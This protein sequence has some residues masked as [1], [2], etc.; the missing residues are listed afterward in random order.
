MGHPCALRDCALGLGDSSVGT[1]RLARVRQAQSKAISS[2]KGEAA[3]GMRRLHETNAELLQQLDVLQRDKDV[4]RR[5][6]EQQEGELR[7][8][9]DQLEMQIRSFDNFKESLLKD[10]QERCEK[11]IDLELSLD[12]SREQYNSLMADT[13]NR[14]LKKRISF[15]ERNVDQLT[16]T[17]QQLVVQNSTYRIENQIAEKKI[18]R[19]NERIQILELLLQDA[20]ERNEK[21]RQQVDK[22][23]NEFKELKRT[24]KLQQSR[25]APNSF[26]TSAVKV[27]TPTDAATG[28]SPTGVSVLNSHVVMPIRGGGQRAAGVIRGGGGSVATAEADGLDSPAPLAPAIQPVT[29]RD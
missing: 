3:E 27:G 15:L 6:N 7:A 4:A 22:M 9:R 13:S 14:K 18:L 8:L 10:L 11:V 21:L 20:R 23:N 5:N 16:Q 2:E 29:A 26:S 12:E 28:S 17:Y 1:G 25:Q 19:K 24:A